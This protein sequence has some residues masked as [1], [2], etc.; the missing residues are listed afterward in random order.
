MVLPN[1]FQSAPVSPRRE[2]AT[3]GTVLV[4]YILVCAFLAA[5]SGMDSPYLTTLAKL[6][7]LEVVLPHLCDFVAKGD[8]TF[9]RTGPELARFMD[10][11]YGFER[12]QG[13]NHRQYP[14]V[15]GWGN[16]MLI[17]GDAGS[18][19]IRSAGPDEIFDTEDDIYLAG[20]S[21]REHIVDGVKNMSRAS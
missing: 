10:E 7:N 20:S 5:C 6:H 4:V 8:M 3:L 16:E 19:E 11:D 9:P 15:D 21:E 17:R 13:E 14:Y 1:E 2:R 12:P 18:Y